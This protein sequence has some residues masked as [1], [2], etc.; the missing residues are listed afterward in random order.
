MHKIKIKQPER[1]LVGGDF[2]AL[3]VRTAVFASGDPAMT[4]AYNEGKDLYSVVAS[5]A[6]GYP[7][8][9]C[10][11]F[12]PEGT[13]L[14]I[15]GKEI[16]CGKKTHTNSILI[17]SIYQ[18]GIPSIA[19]Q[20]GKSVEETKE[21]IE[22]FYKNFPVMTQWFEDSKK[23]TMENGYMLNKVGRKRRLPNAQLPKYSI[24]TSKT[25]GTEGFN[26]LLGCSNKINTE[27]I[28]KYR[29][30]L[31]NNGKFLSNKDYEEIKRQAKVEG[32]EIHNNGAKIAESLRQC[33]NV[34]AQSLGA[35][36]VKKAM[37][38]VEEDE[39]LD[40]LGFDLLIQVH[41]ELIGECP[42]ENAE[43]VANRLS[44]IMSET[45]ASIVPT[46]PWSVDCYKIIWWYADEL[47]TSL[48]DLMLKHNNISKEELY[49]IAC[50][51]HSELLPE[52]IH[53]VLFE[54][55]ELRIS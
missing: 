14:E 38:I 6:Y 52:A 46:L 30:K 29:K 8:E 44:T 4:Q 25:S 53:E 10:L 26:P 7:Y 36:I 13:K 17:G 1:V 3:E 42:K 50:E 31:E 41:D 9:E 35:D 39:E 49:N 54:G 37:L 5:L 12:Y 43:A 40:S 32:V 21:I 15:D 45:A 55:K 2:S 20:I 23:F 18:R 51:E 22:G 28:D 11:E 19:E 24:T 48:Q 27:L 16:I 47:E 33:V 34:Q